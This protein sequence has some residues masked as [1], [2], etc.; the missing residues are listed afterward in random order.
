MDWIP[1]WRALASHPKT[2]RLR[3]ELDCTI[4]EAVGALCLLWSWAVDYAP[5]GDLTRWAD[6]DIA[7]ACAWDGDATEFVAGLT[8]AGFVD[9]DRTL[10][11]W[12][13]YTGKHLAKY[14]ADRAR[15]RGG[16]SA[17][18]PRNLRALSAEPRRIEVDLEVEV[19]PEGEKTKSTA[20]ARRKAEPV[21]EFDRFWAVYP[22]KVGKRRAESAHKRA[23]GRADA[24]VIHAGAERL[25]SD[26]NLPERRF[27]PY[28][29]KWLN[30]DQWN[31]EPLPPRHVSQHPTDRRVRELLGR[32]P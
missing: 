14:E 23:L 29:E 3:R 15:K 25:A 28:P 1:L 26:P 5:D 2:R 30:G 24:G 12:D 10:H 9:S 20:L 6:E 13:E 31:D 7:D 17:E 11:D 4:L 19:D 8:A 18:A 27:I 21:S 22:R 32:Q 16:N